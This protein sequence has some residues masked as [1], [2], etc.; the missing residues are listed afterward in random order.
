M[1]ESICASSTSS[2]LS[3]EVES[4]RFGIYRPSARSEA[5]LERSR[6]MD[7]AGERWWPIFGAAYFLVA[8]K[9]VRGMRLLSPEWRR[10]SARATAPVPI[11]GKVHRQGRRADGE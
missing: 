5:W 2:P 9:R 7:V 8:V 1:K 11:A 10:A 3:F 4:G 6:W